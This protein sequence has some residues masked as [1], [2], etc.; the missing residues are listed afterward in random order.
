LTIE[1]FTFIYS[2][3]ILKSEGMKKNRLIIFT[4]LM[5]LLSISH[6]VMAVNGTND[7][8]N[9][10][11]IAA[12]VVPHH[13]LAK[14]TIA[15]FFSYISQDKPHP[16]TI[17]LLSPDHFNSASLEE[18]I[19]FITV[20][21]ESGPSEIK[22][23]PVDT[24]LLQKLALENNLISSN[25]AITLDFGITNLLPFL[26]SY[27]NQVKV[28]PILVPGNITRNEVTR[29]VESID[30]LSSP[31][32]MMIA[33]VDFSHY[34]PSEVASFHDQ[35]SI[36]V[37]SNFEE[38]HFE[39]IEV[40]SWAALYAVR[41]YA[42]LRE[43]EN[44]LIIAHKNSTDFLPFP[45]EETTSYLSVV[46]QRGE[47]I[48]KGREV[49][50]IL[51][52]GDMMLGRGVAELSK[53]NSIYYP[54]QKIR[55]LLRGV[56]VVFAN[57]EGPIVE[58]PAEFSSNEL[59]FTFSPEV[60]EAMQRSQINLVSLANN[61]LMDRGEEGLK[62]TRDWLEQYQINVIGYPLSPEEE[63]QNSS[64]ATWATEHS[65]FL[66]FNR[67]LPLV[68]FK[69]EI[70]QEVERVKKDNPQKFMIVSMHWGKEYQTVSSSA[71]RQLARQLI[72]A[73]ADLIVGHHPHV[74]QE[75]EMIE[76]KPV[77][78][79][80]G[81]FIFDYQSMP[82]TREGLMVGLT[83]EPDRVTCRLFPLQHHLG[84]PELMR[85]R[86]AETFLQNLAGKCSQ[87][88]REEIEKGIIEM[89]RTN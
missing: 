48:N 81:N 43:S 49:E 33:S 88:L 60:L 25:S 85:Q 15:D 4:V 27:F 21:W 68:H 76:G 16:D 46:F 26:K 17:I 67:V 84:Q 1:N 41:L 75:I 14:E 66:A 63:R 6:P 39:N 38:E 79:S 86:E 7:P 78:Y 23:I 62:E 70:I 20:S 18:E 19:S 77:F 36:R 50:T 55:P 80:L 13:L 5:A 44:P 29:L 35:K 10:F 28:V 71:Q 40:D 56:D 11:A 37:L 58:N 74:V 61:H 47:A 31:D 45:Q 87:S 73:G 89:K 30:R 12:G 69:K 52:A 65:V 3:S 2:S 82:E 64:W 32:T 9:S 53:Q 51:L 72:A 83:V 57:L 24:S 54:F 42:R 8:G 22:G 59:N 34:L